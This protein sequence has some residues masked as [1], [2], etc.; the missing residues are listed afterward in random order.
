[1][2]QNEIF[3]V[4]TQAHVLQVMDTIEGVNGQLLPW[5]GDTLSAT[6]RKQLGV[7]RPIVT[8]LLERDPAQRPSMA[9][10]CEAC[11]RVLAGITTV[12]PVPYS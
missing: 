5:E 2:S 4:C 8:S 6:H 3:S 9:Q 11:D 12:P 7:F 1:M 10:F